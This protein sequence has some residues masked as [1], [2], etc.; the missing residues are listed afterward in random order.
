MDRIQLRRDTA[1]RWVE[2]NPILLEGEVGFET[3]TKRRKIGDGVTPWRNLD[4]LAAENIAQEGGDSTALVMS[5]KAV[6]NELA[7]L[8]SY[9][10]YVI[11]GNNAIGRK[12]IELYVDGLDDNELYTIPQFRQVTYNGS[13]FNR[14]YIEDSKGYV[15]YVDDYTLS[16]DVLPLKPMNNSGISGFV[17]M[18]L[19]ANDITNAVGQL[20][21]QYVSNMDNSPRIKTYFLNQQFV[22]PIA[23]LGGKALHPWLNSM[24]DSYSLFVEDNKLVFANNETWYFMRFPR[25]SNIG[26]T[27][28]PASRI[29]IP[30]WDSHNGVV[31][32][33]IYN[34][35]TKGADGARL[36]YFSTKGV[37]SEIGKNECFEAI[38]NIRR[39]GGSPVVV[40]GYLQEAKVNQFVDSY[41]KEWRQFQGGILQMYS[42]LTKS[43]VSVYRVEDKV[44]FSLKNDQ[45]FAKRTNDSASN[46]FLI[47]ASNG[48]I[49]IPLGNK[50]SGIVVGVIYDPQN[51]NPSSARYGY[52]TTE[53]F[54]SEI[55]DNE[56]FEPIAII[57]KAGGTPVIT[58]GKVYELMRD[59]NLPNVPIKPLV[60]NNVVYRNQLKD[61]SELGVLNSNNDAVNADDVLTLV[62][63]GLTMQQNIFIYPLINSRINK[64]AWRVSFNTSTSANMIIAP[65][66]MESNY[67]RGE[68]IATLRFSVN[69]IDVG[70][71]RVDYSFEANTDYRIDIIRNDKHCDFSIVN[72]RSGVKTELPSIVG[73]TM[74][75]KGLLYDIIGIYNVSEVS[76]IIKAISVESMVEKPYLIMYGDSITAGFYSTTTDGINDKCYAYLVGEAT[77]KKYLSSARGGGAFAGLVGAT[78]NGYSYKGRLDVELPR[79]LPSY[80]MVT[81]GTNGGGEYSDYQQ[82]VEK[83]LSYGVTPILNTIPLRYSDGEVLDYVAS[84]NAAILRI[85]KDYGIHGARLDLA[86]SLNNNGVTPNTSLFNEDGIHPNNDGHKAIFD[87]I[88]SDCPELFV[89]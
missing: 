49:S 58:G 41:R 18:N 8:E 87:R 33:V 74:G 46:Y 81:I 39:I 85:W 5:Q 22:Q 43:D 2:L 63:N 9:S 56:Y 66:V 26:Y 20:V 65:Y 42:G 82:V 61:Y 50:P 40:S 44:V 7:K 67:V 34:A 48:E 60:S 69:K 3:D 4:Y 72:L 45:I 59:T 17:V 31:I 84:T 29:E 13:I 32:G 53:G 1:V 27:S 52:Y 51:A 12:L 15:A 16:S 11:N 64:S 57:Q 78:N 55:A 79:L 71:N 76:P 23:K 21:N 62:E 30:D 73:E 70:E 37:S 68:T 28:L 47:P 14:I 38:A 75:S 88:K 77:S 54:V 25:E 6:K 35:T 10:P 86:T 83:I 24:V 19:T 89:A 36:G 80:A